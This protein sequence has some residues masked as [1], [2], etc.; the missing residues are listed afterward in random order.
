MSDAQAG[1]L[2]IAFRY[3]DDWGLLLVNLADLKTLLMYIASDEGKKELSMEYGAITPGTLQVLMR[4]ILELEAQGGESLFGERSLDVQDFCISNNHDFAPINI[5]RLMYAVRSPLVFSTFI[6][7]LLT[8]VYNTFPEVGDLPRPRLVFIVDE[9]HILFQ[10][11]PKAF[12]AEIT[13]MM[14]LIR[15]KGVSVLFCTQN[16]ADIPDDILGQL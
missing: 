5:L 15:S 16:P 4:K 8:E 9:A 3:A 7:S 12:L 1:A 13:M 11:A 6:L 2:T 10:D 14:K